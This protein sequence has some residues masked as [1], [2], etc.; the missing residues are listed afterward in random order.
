MT[1]ITDE[2][3][4]TMLS[5]HGTVDA[6][7]TLDWF[8]QTSADIGLQDI[9]VSEADRDGWLR[10]YGKARDINALTDRLGMAGLRWR[11]V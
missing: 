6:Y 2:K 1:P 3:G 8:D 10:F 4:N 5:T 7:V 11:K 9:T